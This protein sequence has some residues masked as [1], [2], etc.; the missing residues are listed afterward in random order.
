MKFKKLKE[1]IIYLVVTLFLISSF[2][3][4]GIVGV[5]LL[6]HLKYL[7]DTHTTYNM[8]VS[9]ETHPFTVGVSLTSGIIWIITALVLLV[10]KK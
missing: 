3:L 8:I 10:R 5:T 2:A 4:I 7:I 9:F 1:I 6:Y